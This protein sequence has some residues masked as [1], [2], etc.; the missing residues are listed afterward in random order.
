MIAESHILSKEYRVLKYANREQ[1]Y[2]VYFNNMV[3]FFGVKKEVQ[4][5]LGKKGID[6]DYI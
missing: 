6:C 5:F 1:P 4:D 3:V 2:T